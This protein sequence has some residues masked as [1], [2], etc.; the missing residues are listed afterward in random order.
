[1]NAFLLLFC[2]SWSFVFFITGLFAGAI[3]TILAEP[4]RRCT[5]ELRSLWPPSTAI[6][7]AFWPF[8]WSRRP[9]ILREK[10]GSDVGVDF[11]W[12]KSQVL[13]P[14]HLYFSKNKQNLWF[15]VSSAT[16]QSQLQRNFF[17]KDQRRPRQFSSL[18]PKHENWP[19]RRGLHGGV[20]A[21]T[22]LPL[23]LRFGCQH[24]RALG[25]WQG[26]CVERSRLWLSPVDLWNSWSGAMFCSF[27][28]WEALGWMVG[29]EWKSCG[30][31]F[32][33]F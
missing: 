21:F 29:S 3:G 27:F 30:V 26:V 4:L 25:G 19:S 12:L 2:E 20:A 8:R 33:F 31:L 13:Q 7:M 32:L 17:Q 22:C 16:L 14:V 24:T 10:S 9:Q 23:G 28:L 1:M 18:K 5:V 11:L 6:P 15:P